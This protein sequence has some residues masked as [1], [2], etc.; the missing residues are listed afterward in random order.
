MIIILNSGGVPDPILSSTLAN[1]S[2]AAFGAKLP[3]GLYIPPL[4]SNEN[5]FIVAQ[6]AA[7]NTSNAPV[8]GEDF[9]F[10][11]GATIGSSPN[12]SGTLWTVQSLMYQLQDAFPQRYMGSVHIAVADVQRRGACYDF[13][14]M[15]KTLLSG[16]L[17]LGGNVFFHPGSTVGPI[18][19]AGD[20]RWIGVNSVPVVA[21]PLPVS[22]IQSA[23][24]PMI[25]NG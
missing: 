6:R 16:E 25:L 19:P 12:R 15:F 9:S 10:S 4:A 2:S 13:A 17:Q 5:L 20:R 8:I 23:N 1:V 14:G 11:L 21:S 18:F 3:I 24:N 7:Y 22:K